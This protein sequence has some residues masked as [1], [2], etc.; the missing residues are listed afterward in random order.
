MSVKLLVAD[1][2]EVIRRG[3]AKYIRLHTDRF[4]KIYEAENGQEA[5]DLLL[6]YQPD[7]LLLDVQMPLKNGL[8]VM[9]EAERAGL[10]PIVVILSGYDEFKYAQQALRYGAKEYLLKP[11]RASDILKCLNRLVDDSLGLEE[12]C[13]QEEENGTNQL[14]KRAKEYIA[15][16]YMENITLSDTAEI[17]G[18]TGGYLSTLFQKSL[19][20]GFIDYLNRVRIERACCYLEQNYFKTYEI[21]YKAVSY[22]HLTL[23][24]IA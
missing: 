15:E 22:T 23:P 24:T 10:H 20:C 4:D 5:I 7:I 18:I 16:H 3:V 6:K 12:P 17:L 13:V 19:Q 9:K 1:D 8:D 2:E 11:A 21:A 14:V